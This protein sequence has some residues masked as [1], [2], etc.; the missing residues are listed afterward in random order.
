MTYFGVC[1]LVKKGV[2]LGRIVNA[3]LYNPISHRILIDKSRLVDEGEIHLLNL[4]G[5]RG[6]EIACR[7]SHS[8]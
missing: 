5:D 6:N 8:R 4:T 3:Y 2:K 1:R 7:P